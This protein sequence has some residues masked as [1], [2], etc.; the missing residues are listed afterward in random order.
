MTSFEN[1]TTRKNIVISKIL[2]KNVSPRSETVRKLRIRQIVGLSLV[3][4]GLVKIDLEVVL[5]ISR[6]R[7]SSST[8][9]RSWTIKSAKLM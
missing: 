6:K 5:E 3:K 2:S 4:M 9:E 8:V 7:K 1:R